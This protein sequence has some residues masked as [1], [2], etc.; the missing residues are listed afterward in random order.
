MSTSNSSFLIEPTINSNTNVS[1]NT[2]ISPSLLPTN[3]NSND[4]TST[5][6]RRQALMFSSLNNNNT[7]TN[8]CNTSIVSS[9][10]RTNLVGETRINS[11]S[12]L[13]LHPLSSTVEFQ[14]SFVV[15]FPHHHSSERNRQIN[16]VVSSTQRD[17]NIYSF[18]DNQLHQQQNLL[19][20]S[21]SFLI[22]SQQ[23]INHNASVE[24][25][26]FIGTNIFANNS[27]AACF[28]IL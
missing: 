6:Q 26:R 12:S 4:S 25:R 18:N 5:T 7:S 16:E 19:P 11:S 13:T 21:M 15:A 22:N 10:N 3:N 17:S 20:F 8:V 14:P 24:N 9:R 28:L 23:A 2:T 27:S 1:L